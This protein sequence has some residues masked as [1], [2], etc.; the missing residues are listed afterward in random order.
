MMLDRRR[1]VL[2]HD[3]SG[4]EN[5]S[6]VECENAEAW[7]PLPAHVPF[8]GTAVARARCSE[9]AS[10]FLA[11]TSLP[12][13]DNRL[14]MSFI[15]TR[16][17]WLHIRQTYTVLADYLRPVRRF[18]GR[19]EVFLSRAD[20]KQ[21]RGTWDK[22]VLFTIRVVDGRAWQLEKKFSQF[23]QLDSELRKK[24][25]GSMPPFPDLYHDWTDWARMTGSLSQKLKVAHQYLSPPS[26]CATFPLSVA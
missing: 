2:Q 13:T 14:T 15:G 21:G 18:A 6:C 25:P 9:T 12:L 8:V 1:N 7:L 17:T 16:F 22:F 20:I 3:D 11:S 24:Y 4:A 26:C 23:V 19:P 10:A 5:A